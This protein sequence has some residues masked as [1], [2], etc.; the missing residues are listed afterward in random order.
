MARCSGLEFVQV[1]CLSHL[2]ISNVATTFSSLISLINHQGNS[3]SSE[4]NPPNQKQKELFVQ[5]AEGEG[6]VQA[7]LAA[8]G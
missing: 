8:T 4:H 3:N 7:G 5:K 1:R 6:E 2:A